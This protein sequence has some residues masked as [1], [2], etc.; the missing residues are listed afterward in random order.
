MTGF[1]PATVPRMSARRSGRPRPST[2]RCT[3]TPSPPAPSCCAM[4]PMRWFRRRSATTRRPTTRHAD[5][6]LTAHGVDDLHGDD[7]RRQRRREGHCRQSAG[8]HDRPLVHDGHRRPGL[9]LHDLGRVGN[10]APAPAMRGRGTRRWELGV[11][12]RATMDGTI[13]GVRF[14]KAASNGGV[15]TGTLW[16]NDGVVDPAC[17][18]D[19]HVPDVQ[20]IDLRALRVF[21]ERSADRLPGRAGRGTVLTVAPYTR[22][23]DRTAV[24]SPP[25]ATSSPASG[26]PRGRP[27]PSSPAIRRTRA[28]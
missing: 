20:D 24:E 23:D 5:A 14:Y 10:D 22:P 26:A 13:T 17:P 18:A 6:H 15:H 28:T 8:E 9:P 2:S 4:P 12:F 11:R 3:R 19:H 25:S 7:R 27:R 16:S 21:P 1:T